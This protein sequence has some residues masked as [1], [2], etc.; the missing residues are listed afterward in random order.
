MSERI[1]DLYEPSVHIYLPVLGEAA[2][3]ER[4]SAYPGGYEYVAY[5]NLDCGTEPGDPVSRSLK[6]S[7]G[8][9]L[10][11]F[12]LVFSIH[13]A[14][15]DLLRQE[16]WGDTYAEATNK[17]NARLQVIQNLVKWSPPF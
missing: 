16:A 17:L 1:P 6:L 9:S 13:S 3:L 4:R 15:G 7:Q 14:S 8:G 12:R 5:D 11:R 10:N 2:H